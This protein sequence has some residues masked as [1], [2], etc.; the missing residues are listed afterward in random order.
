MA[1][2]FSFANRYGRRLAL[3]RKTGAVRWTTDKLDDPD[4][5]AQDRI[6]SVLLVKDAIVAVA[7]DTAFSV[8]PDRTGTS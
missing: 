4:T 2:A 1:Q 7:G 8:R 6:P 3:D 5:S